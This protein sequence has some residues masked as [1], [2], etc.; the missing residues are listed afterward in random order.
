[1]KKL[2]LLT[3]L[4]LHQRNTDII[5]AVQMCEAFAQRGFRVELITSNSHFKSNNCENLCQFFGINEHSFSIRRLPILTISKWKLSC[6]I[7]QLLSNV[8]FEFYLFVLKRETSEN[9]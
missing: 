1:M 2:N 7:S 8:L 6:S 9:S 4:S 5:W 3:S